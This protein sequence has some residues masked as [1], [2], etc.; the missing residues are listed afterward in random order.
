MGFSKRGLL[1]L[2]GG[3]S[4]FLA[5]CGKPTEAEKA[6][7]AKSAY[8]K[9][10][11]LYRKGDYGGAAAYLRKAEAGMAYLSPEQIRELKYKLALSLYREGKYEDAILE[12][13]DYIY[14]YPTAPNVEEAYLYLIKAY[15]KISPDAWRDQTY[16]EKA[17]KLAQEFLQKFPNSKYLPQVEELIDEAKRK[18]AKHQYLIAKF[19]EDY[20]YYY[21]AAVRFEYLLLTYPNYI[22]T[23]DVLFH[24][25]KNL[26]LVPEYAQKKVSY[27][28]EKYGELQRRIE[29][30]EVLDLKAAK[31]RLEFYKGQIQRW[32][33]ISEE[34][35]KKAEENLKIYKE[36][37]GE[38]KYYKLL[39]KIKKEGRVKQSWIERIL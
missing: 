30:K 9:G 31:K 5:S 7:E 14:Y 19:Y 32:E 1:L 29:N 37:F 25:I 33:K 26:F 2:A 35:V 27:W 4:I 20:G 6:K 36:R 39:L 15:L 8:A 12:L 10:I 34:S 22:N 13:E 28:R 17:L 21:P 3:L 23:R 16:T 38:D 11:E 18:L 24:Y